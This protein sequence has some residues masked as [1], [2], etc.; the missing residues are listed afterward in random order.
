MKGKLLKEEWRNETAKEEFRENDDEKSNLVAIC[1]S[2]ADGDVS[3]S[4]NCP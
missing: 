4:D 3:P 1:A 2:I